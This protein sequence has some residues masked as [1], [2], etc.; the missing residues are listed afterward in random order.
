[1]KEAL[2]KTDTCGFYVEGVDRILPLLEDSSPIYLA[3]TGS[4]QNRLEHEIICSQH[5]C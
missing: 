2:N 1:M 3:R 4:E 5:S